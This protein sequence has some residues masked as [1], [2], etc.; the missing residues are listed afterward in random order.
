M[1]NWKGGNT[2]AAVA[3]LEL[4]EMVRSG[5]EFE[6]TLTVDG[7]RP[8]SMRYGLIVGKTTTFGAT[9]TAAWHNQHGD[10]QG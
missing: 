8:A 4:L 2:L 9:F 3:E 5:K 10:N 6:L 7:S 1:S